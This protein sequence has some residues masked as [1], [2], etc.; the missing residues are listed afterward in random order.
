MKDN[1]DLFSTSATQLRRV[2]GRSCTSCHRHSTDSPSSSSPSVTIDIET[3]QRRQSTTA[4]EQSTSR[5]IG[6]ATDGQRCR[7]HSDRWRYA[8]VREKSFGA[9]FFSDW[10]ALFFRIWI[11]RRLSSINVAIY[12]LARKNRR[13]FSWRC[14]LFRSIRDCKYSS[15]AS[16]LRTIGD[17]LHKRRR[18]W[19]WYVMFVR[20]V[21]WVSWMLF[22]LGNNSNNN[23]AT[24]PTTMTTITTSNNSNKSSHAIISSLAKQFNKKDTSLNVS[25]SSNN[26]NVNSVNS[27][28]HS[29]GGQL[30]HSQLI[31]NNN[32]HSGDDDVTIDDDDSL[33][34]SRLVSA[35]FLPFDSIRNKTMLF[36][37][38]NS[39]MA[40]VELVSSQ[41]NQK[42]K[43]Q[44]FN[45]IVLWFVCGGVVNDT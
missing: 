10:Q 18:R 30:S 34:Q 12:G 22:C 42:N 39:V 8:I 23:N 36:C 40:L 25:N 19:S 24:M 13:E 16:Q 26:S 11:A 29:G 7:Q 38:N 27:N 4:N 9:V 5:D 44:F 35:C 37:R 41:S 2:V 21:T 20:F 1:G 17:L 28:G 45:G 31:V 15:Y 32:R 14:W 33:M 43:K 6:S 3:K